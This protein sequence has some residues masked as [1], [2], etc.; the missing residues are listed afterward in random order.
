MDLNSE[1]NQ[2]NKPDNKLT[3]VAFRC[4]P[5]L[6]Q[7]L[8]LKAKQSG[9]NSLSEYLA[10]RLAMD[11]KPPINPDPQK[12]AAIQEQLTKLQKKVTIYENPMLLRY[13]TKLQNKTYEFRDSYGNERHIT[14]ASPKDVFELMLASFKIDL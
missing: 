1:T 2:N 7:R 12:I 9:F 14:V 11:D 6:R 10:N 8:E 4:F 13:F 3:V 5:E